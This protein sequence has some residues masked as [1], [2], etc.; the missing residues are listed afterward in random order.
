ML[1][2]VGLLKV[3]A[4]DRKYVVPKSEPFK[5]AGVRRNLI[6][7]VSASVVSAWST[8]IT[9]GWLAVANV[10][11]AYVVAGGVTVYSYMLGWH[12]RG[13]YDH[14]CRVAEWK[15]QHTP[16]IIELPPDEDLLP[17]RDAPSS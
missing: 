13:I 16:M 15:A 9:Y 6:L 3:E 5:D 1:A 8:Y 12:S 17:P 2:A 10:V 4:V 14:N 11:A 7:I